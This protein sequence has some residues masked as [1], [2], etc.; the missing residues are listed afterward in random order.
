LSY[1]VCKDWRKINAMKT[2]GN[3][4]TIEAA[5]TLSPGR[6]LELTPEQCL[7][8]A[9][10]CELIAARLRFAAG[11]RAPSEVLNS[12]SRRDPELDIGVLPSNAPMQRLAPRY[13]LKREVKSW[14]LIFE[15]EESRLK[16]EKGLQYTAYLLRH[17]EPIHCVELAQRVFG[18][19]I[20]QEASLA[21]DASVSRRKIEAEARELMQVLN[22]DN[23][24]EFEKEEA[25]STLSSLADAH[26]AAARYVTNGSEKMIRAVQRAIGRFRD[27][28][29][30]ARDDQGMPHPVKNA[31]GRHIRKYLCV[32]SSRY[33]GSRQGRAKSGLA[34]CMTYEPP[35]GVSWES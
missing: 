24:T 34:G 15:G 2:E 19:T 12:E 10:L 8:I 22:D 29:L 9:D 18:R 4:N 13:A 35:P 17:P 21:T 11:D 7:S 23:A 32:P 14:R 33:T 3:E 20:I 31:F 26:K 28:L 25:R 5:P 1:P 30:D 6:Y 16:D 27:R